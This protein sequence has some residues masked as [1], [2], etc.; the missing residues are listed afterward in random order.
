MAEFRSMLNH[1]GCLSG[2]SVRAG[3][4]SPSDTRS[5]R[6][7]SS[8]SS[9]GELSR[10][11]KRNR[12]DSIDSNSTDETG[13]EGESK[14]PRQ[15]AQGN[16]I[17]VRRLACPFFKHN[18]K[19]HLKLRSCGGPGWESTHRVK[20][21]LYRN[22]KLPIHCNRCGSVMSTNA[23]LIAHQRQAIACEVQLVNLPEGIDDNQEK[24]LRKRLRGASE[25][26]K[27]FEIYKII[28]PDEDGDLIPSP[29]Y[30]SGSSS[31]QDAVVQY[32]R[33]QRRELLRLVRKRLE[34]EVLGIAGPL[35]DAL[36]AQFVGIVRDAQIEVFRSYQG[37]HMSK[38]KQPLTPSEQSRGSEEP[39]KTTIE[40][41]QYPAI[42]PSTSYS[43]HEGSTPFLI[44][45]G[46]V[47]A[48]GMD[49]GL[50]IEGFDFDPSLFEMALPVLEQQQHGSMNFGYPTDLN[51][52]PY[53]GY[54]DPSAPSFHD[55][56]SIL[57]FN[58]SSDQPDSRDQ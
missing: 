17:G 22:H 57:L 5:Q 38:G 54:M 25:E 15:G 32:E 16:G 26:E 33:V 12:E 40:Q 55:K 8:A 46:P 53:S 6:G 58:N 42:P 30:D 21:H 39:R 28:F 35:E 4:G 1:H 9:S 49:S 14:R 43:Q 52:I 44:P 24:A 23:D 31:P 20:E 18:T 37:N 10:S 41:P 7:M 51:T 47:H 45:N 13:R 3:A 48:E 56:N 27:W 19:K 11:T 29:Y 2:V 50:A 36:R 34:E